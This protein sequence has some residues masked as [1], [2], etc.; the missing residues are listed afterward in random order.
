MSC[1]TPK[2]RRVGWRAESGSLEVRLG[3]EPS[4]F[5]G[6]NQLQ[7]RDVTGWIILYVVL[8]W[9]CCQN[10]TKL[11]HQLIHS[12]QKFLWEGKKKKKEII[13]LISQSNELVLYIK[14]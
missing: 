5:L 12:S 8:G 11:L 3:K 1:N 6:R 4:L 13:N 7:V 10:P 2:M 9:F 14:I